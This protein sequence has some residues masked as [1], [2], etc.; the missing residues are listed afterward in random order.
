MFRK[1]IE[2]YTFLTKSIL[3]RLITYATFIFVFLIA[4]MRIINNSE[5]SN[6]ILEVIK[7]YAT[8]LFI[9]TFLIFIFCEVKALNFSFLEKDRTL[10]EFLQKN[11][12]E[13]TS[14]KHESSKRYVIILILSFFISIVLSYLI[15]LKIKDFEQ[16]LILAFF[17]WNIL[18]IWKINYFFWDLFMFIKYKF[19]RGIMVFLGAL[20][21]LYYLKIRFSLAAE[22]LSSETF[23]IIDF[24]FEIIINLYLFT[25]L[26]FRFMEKSQSRKDEIE[27]F[28]K[29]VNEIQE[30]SNSKTEN[31]DSKKDQTDTNIKKKVLD[32][33]SSKIIQNLS[34]TRIN[35][36]FYSTIIL[37]AIALCA[38]LTIEYLNWYFAES[39]GWV[40]GSTIFYGTRLFAIIPISIIVVIRAIISQ[41]PDKKYYDNLLKQVQK[42][43]KKLT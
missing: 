8:S 35:A 41:K 36:K 25:S 34:N 1:N 2:G 3:A 13:L 12:M 9:F 43:S 40:F 28:I 24:I 42:K 31:I 15:I 29:K 37:N 11:N 20:A 33:E 18:L 4:L 16:Y 22:H 26:S 39:Y 19:F 10:D 7:Y 6:A 32:A 23:G 14:S 17:I 5:Y 38:F 21:Y 30:E 27:S